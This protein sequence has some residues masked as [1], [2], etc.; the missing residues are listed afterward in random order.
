MAPAAAP[1]RGH[2]AHEA[3]KWKG[4]RSSVRVHVLPHDVLAIVYEIHVFGYSNLTYYSC[5][6]TYCTV[7]K[8]KYTTYRETDA[9]TTNEVSL[10]HKNFR[11][12]CLVLST[13]LIF[14]FKSSI[15]TPL[16]VFVQSNAGHGV[17]QYILYWKYFES[18]QRKQ[19]ARIPWRLASSDHER[20]DVSNVTSSRNFIFGLFIFSALHRTSYFGTYPRE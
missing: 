15:A 14:D 10:F 16:L 3:T 19:A 6:Y 5:V 9:Q 7:R 4:E 1:R 8:C 18:F 13:Q 12:A 17:L 2:G 11:V 20:D